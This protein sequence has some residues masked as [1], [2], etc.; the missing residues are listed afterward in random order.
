[1]ASSSFL[2]TNIQVSEQDIDG[3]RKPDLFIFEAE[4]L[5]STLNVVKIDAVLLFKIKTEYV[6]APVMVR[7]GF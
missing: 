1:M 2:F 5:K 3:D 7:V 4:L 6:S